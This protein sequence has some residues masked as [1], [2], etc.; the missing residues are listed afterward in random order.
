PRRVVLEVPGGGDP[1]PDACAA[2]AGTFSGQRG[3][4]W[5]DGHYGNTLYNHFAAPNP[6][7]WDC[8]N[9]SHNKGLSTAR[10]CHAGGVGVLNA[11]GSVRFVR[12][13]VP[14]GVWRAMATRSGG[15]VMTDD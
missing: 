14:L 2:A 5:I 12:D 7:T 6:P 11:D 13:A 1:T 9:G 4:K 15:E 10:S 8:G 3:A